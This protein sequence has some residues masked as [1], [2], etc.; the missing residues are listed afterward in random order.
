MLSLQR[1]WRKTVAW[2]NPGEQKRQLVQTGD[3]LFSRIWDII[4]TS[5]SGNKKLK[6]FEKES[7]DVMTMIHREHLETTFSTNFTNS[8]IMVSTKIMLRFKCSI[9][10]SFPMFQM[11]QPRNSFFAE[12]IHSK[13]GRV[14]TRA[15]L[16]RRC[17][18]L[19]DVLCF[20]FKRFL[21]NIWKQRARVIQLSLSTS[22]PVYSMFCA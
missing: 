17:F 6:K 13:F 15:M 16:L 14:S 4:Q 5:F 9:Q 10:T 20:V 11:R 1:L 18:I 2:K 22:F 7:P 8:K 12:F 3:P 19:P 21:Q